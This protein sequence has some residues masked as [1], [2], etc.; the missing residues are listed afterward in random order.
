MTRRTPGSSASRPTSWS[1]SISATTSR[2]TS[3][4]GATGGV[5]AAPIV[6][7]FMKVALADKPA[8]PFRVPAGIKL[9]RIDAEDRHAGGAGRPAR[10]PGSLQA[11]HRA[12]RQLLGDRR[13]RRR[14]PAAAVSRPRPTARCA[15][16]APAG[17]GSGP[18]RRTS[19]PTA[20]ASRSHAGEVKQNSGGRA[21]RQRPQHPGLEAE[22]RDRSRR[23][24]GRAPKDRRSRAPA[25]RTR[26]P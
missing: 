21:G 1:A 14:G 23:P 12:A 9:I 26:S 7:D 19:C 3:A 4:R 6:R 20:R 10:H 15:A 5:L 22:D 16:P 8:V 2:A 24:T 13:H 25:H 18:G 17:C 11:R